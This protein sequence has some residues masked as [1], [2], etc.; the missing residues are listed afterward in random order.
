MSK[1]PPLFRTR[2]TQSDSSVSRLASFYMKTKTEPHT[3]FVCAMQFVTTMQGVHKALIQA[4]QKELG[5][6]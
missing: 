6:H 4:E 5:S 1:S 2:Q 3:R